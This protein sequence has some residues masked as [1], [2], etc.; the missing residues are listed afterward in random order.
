M[1]R[2]RRQVEDLGGTFEV[3]NGEESGLAIRV[4]IPAQV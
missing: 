1:K 4:R 3:R 2:S